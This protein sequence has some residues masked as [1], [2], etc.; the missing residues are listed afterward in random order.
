MEYKHLCIECRLY[1]YCQ[2]EFGVSSNNLSC[3]DFE[4]LSEEE[5]E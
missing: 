2:D 1:E 5:N 4:P 3:I